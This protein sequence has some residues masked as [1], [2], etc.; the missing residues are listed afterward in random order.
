MPIV[1]EHCDAQLGTDT[2]GDVMTVVVVDAGPEA[3][4]TKLRDRYAH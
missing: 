3:T 4:L 2:N 1:A